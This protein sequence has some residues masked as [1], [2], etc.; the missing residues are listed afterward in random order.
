MAV[1]TSMCFLMEVI[2]EVILIQC[3]FT[4][5]FMLMNNRPTMPQLWWMTYTVICGTAMQGGNY[6][7]SLLV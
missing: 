7:V 5:I 3:N 4:L 6:K 1:V 2:A